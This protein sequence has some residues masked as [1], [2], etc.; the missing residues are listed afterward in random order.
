MNES[1]HTSYEYPVNRVVGRSLPAKEP[2]IIRFFC[3]KWLIERSHIY[4]RATLYIFWT[5]CRQSRWCV[6]TYCNTLQQCRTA[7]HCIN[8]ELQH[9]AAAQNCDTLQQRRAATHCSN[10]KMRHTATT[11]NC[12]TLQQ[13]RTA[14]HCSNTELRYTAT[15]QNCN[16]LQQHKIATYC[17]NT[18]LQHTATTQNCNTMQKHRTAT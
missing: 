8:V 13:H 16:T 2:L 9:T 6:N 11:Q 18:K 4:E 12:D 3:R 17:N 7:T 1:H 14:T 10:V 15:T 5:P